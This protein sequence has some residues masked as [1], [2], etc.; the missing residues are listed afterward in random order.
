MLAF[1]RQ[2]EQGVFFRR[3]AA[4]GRGTAPDALPSGGSFQPEKPIFVDVSHYGPNELLYWKGLV[5]DGGAFGA[6]VAGAPRRCVPSLGQKCA[7][8]RNMV[9]LTKVFW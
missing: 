7:T 3:F 2:R 1:L 8:L 6:R 5:G 4:F 9:L